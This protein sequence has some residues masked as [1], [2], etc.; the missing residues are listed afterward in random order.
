MLNEH[1][2]FL[3]RHNS[4]HPWYYVLGGPPLT[5]KQILASVKRQGYH[6]YLRDEIATAASRCEPRRS[7]ELRALRSRAL[8][9]LRFDLSRYRS[10][11][12]ELRAH[13]TSCNDVVCTD[14][15]VAVSLKH[16]HIFNELAHL[17]WINDLLTEQRDLFDC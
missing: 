4:G 17:A 12:R 15:H 13:R 1:L 10:A 2:Y 3:R 11:V 7:S 14:A 16:N 5:P 9:S 6:G 8:D